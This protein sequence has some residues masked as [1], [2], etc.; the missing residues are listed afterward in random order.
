MKTQKSRFQLLTAPNRARVLDTLDAFTR[1]YLI[2]A[3]W[4]S[5]DSSGEPLDRAYSL[6]DYS[7]SALASAIHDCARFQR[8][9]ETTIAAAIASGDVTCGPDFCE[10][11]RAGHDF[12]LTR[13]RHGAGFWDGDW[14]EAQAGKLTQAAH[15]FGEVNAEA[16]SDGAIHFDRENEFWQRAAGLHWSQT[17]ANRREYRGSCV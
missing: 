13:N 5:V 15:A 9:N 17:G 11:G 8:E 6:E 7:A 16:G 10:R 14:P 4:S 12:W 1:A 3:L 2:T